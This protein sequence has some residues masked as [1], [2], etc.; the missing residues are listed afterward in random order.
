MEKDLLIGPMAVVA[1]AH[2]SLY[3][4][5]EGQEEDLGTIAR[6]CW[7]ERT[8]DAEPKGRRTASP[9]SRFRRRMPLACLL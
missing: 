7:E 8:K 4:P 1:V 5:V 6:S 9:K 3:C 2:S